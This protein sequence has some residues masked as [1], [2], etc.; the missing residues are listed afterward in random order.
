[1]KC[2]SCKPESQDFTRHRDKS[3]FLYTRIQTDIRQ[4]RSGRFQ[5]VE[6]LLSRGVT[7]LL[8]DSSMDS[9]S[10]DNHE[11][12]EAPVARLAI[13]MRQLFILITAMTLATFQTHAARLDWLLDVVN[14]DEI[15]R[16]QA[17]FLVW[18]GV[19]HPLSATFEKVDIIDKDWPFYLFHV[20]ISSPGFEKEHD[21]NSSDPSAL[22]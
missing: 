1:M 16:R 12:S 4:D 2:L 7:L 21:G 19:S 20:V 9:L 14:N 22:S 11:R 18:D 5:T 6:P 17:E 8:K 15:A 3:W 13:T 10:P